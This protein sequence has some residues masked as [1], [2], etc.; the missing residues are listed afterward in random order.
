MSHASASSP[1]RR[2]SFAD[3][4]SL[5]SL[6]RNKWWAFAATATVLMMTMLFLFV[7][8]RSYR[9]DARLFVR[10]GRE[11]VTVDPTAAAAGQVLTL[12]DSQQREIQS[13]LDIFSS[14]WLLEYAVDKL[15]VDYVLDGPSDTSEGSD[16]SSANQPSFVGAQIG[17]VTGA[18]RAALVPVKLADPANPRAKAIEVL[19][20]SVRVASEDESNVVAVEVQAETPRMAQKIGE[21]LLEAFQ[22]RHL[23]AHRSQGSFEFF[24]EQTNQAKQALEKATE[25]LALAKSEGGFASIDA[26]KQVLADRLREVEL[27]IL[28]TAAQEEAALALTR[29]IRLAT[30]RMPEYVTQS[31]VTGVTNT[32]R[33]TIR[34]PLYEA[35]LR[36]AQLQ[37]VYQDEH[38]LVKKADQEIRKAKAIYES[39]QVEPQ[40][41]KSLNAARQEIEITLVREEAALASARARM[42]ELKAQRQQLAQETRELNQKEMEI[43]DLQRQV[44]VLDGKYRRYVESLEQTRIDQ[45]LE[46]DRLSNVNVIQPPTFNDDPV[47]F[48]N[49]LIALGGFVASILGG[50]GAALGIEFLRDDI[51]T[52]SDV[53]RVL[54][55]PVLATIPVAADHRAVRP[56][57]AGA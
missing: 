29:D 17:R 36:K 53:H 31:E 33:D 22:N 39:E 5:E 16:D 35:E 38:P 15:G 54:G 24:A 27:E 46:K 34:A 19:E 21:T 51:S 11:S 45:A 48:S 55:L 56:M 30:E 40:V 7:R 9:S 2:A 25:D 18:V 57:P 6:F 32:S 50:L 37:S 1:S 13:T 41:T 43:V 10:L 42:A 52:P 4:C 20:K 14:Q 8:E 44:D 28:R 12:S 49:S 3:V 23:M 26:Q 47:D